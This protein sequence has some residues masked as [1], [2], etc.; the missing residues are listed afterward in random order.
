MQK[1]NIKTSL[2]WIR[3]KTLDRNIPAPTHIYETLRSVFKHDLIALMNIHLRHIVLV[4]M[5]QIDFI[6][7][8]V[9]SVIF[10]RKVEI[11]SAS[12]GC[13]SSSERSSTALSR[14]LRVMSERCHTQKIYKV[15][16]TF[17]YLQRVPFGCLSLGSMPWHTSISVSSGIWKP[18]QQPSWQIVPQSKLGLK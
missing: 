18:H 10:C 1:S 9:L 6:I 16:L 3:I 7:L 5:L 17:D 2:F 11:L 12:I 14:S 13:S 4:Y 15:K 8:T